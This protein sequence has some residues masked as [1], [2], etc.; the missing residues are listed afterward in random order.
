M[1]MA[2]TAIKRVAD[3]FASL[4]MITIPLIYQMIDEDGNSK[5]TKE[6]NK[7]KEKKYTTRNI[8]GQIKTNEF[9]TN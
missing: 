6:K 1:D 5:S 3:T 4:E 7:K 2:K 9:N 8:K